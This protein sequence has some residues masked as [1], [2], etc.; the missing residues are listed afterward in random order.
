M[1]KKTMFEMAFPNANQNN[2]ITFT[3]EKLGGEK[4]M[5]YKEAKEQ[6]LA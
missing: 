6:F 2:G 5:E 3:E 4:T 1:T